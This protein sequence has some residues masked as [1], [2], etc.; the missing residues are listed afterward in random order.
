V[1]VPYHA[2]QNYIAKLIKA[3]AAWRFVTKRAS[4]SRGR[5]WIARSR[6]SLRRERERAGFAGSE[7]AN[8]LARYFGGWRFGFA[9]A[10]LSTGEFGCEVRAAALDDDRAR[11]SPAELLI[12]TDKRRASRAWKDAGV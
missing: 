4:R 8:Y 12:K 10:D 9:Y 1:R 5:S 2:A 7:E 6:R 11:V 3:G